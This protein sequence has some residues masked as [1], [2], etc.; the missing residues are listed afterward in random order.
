LGQGGKN[1]TNLK[2][3]GMMDFRAGSVRFEYV[4]VGW[5]ED[6][7]YGTVIPRSEPAAEWNMATGANKYDFVY[8]QLQSTL[9][10]S[11]NKQFTVVV[12]KVLKEFFPTTT[13]FTEEDNNVL[14]QQ[15][16]ALNLNG[17][18][19]VPAFQPALCN[20]AK[21]KVNVRATILLFGFQPETDADNGGVW[22]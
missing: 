21:Y 9:L 14:A 19:E 18:V 6:N 7:N 13:F 10:L 12:N 1:Y 5:G 2:N 15:Y 8:P 17:S 4:C 11:I 16:N 3:L 20:E 22:L